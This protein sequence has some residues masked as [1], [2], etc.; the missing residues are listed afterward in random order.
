MYRTNRREGW[1]FRSVSAVGCT[2]ILVFGISACGSDDENS[3]SVATQTPA[4]AAVVAKDNEQVCALAT[5]MD[6]QDNFPT[7]EQL[8]RYMALAPTEIDAAADTA[9]KVL[10]AAAG[11]MRKVYL[12]LADDNVEQSIWEINAWETDNCGID[13]EEGQRLE[14]GATR[15]RETGATVVDVIA[16]D[17]AFQL[18]NDAISPGRT[19]LVLLNNGQEA[20][21]FVLFKLVEGVTLEQVFESEDGDAGLV[22]GTWDSGIAAPGGLDDEIITLDLEAG[23]YGMA[24]FVSGADGTP[25]A[26]MGMTLEFTVA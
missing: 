12:S 7:N 4:A 21:F 6:N 9:G 24:C 5:E 10:I 22:E 1:N 17:Y 25:H 15:E 26:F 23:N 19:S 20:H 3:G 18:G 16:T 13:H 2:A 8:T 14:G 11:D